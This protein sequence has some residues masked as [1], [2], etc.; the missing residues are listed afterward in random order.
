VPITTSQLF[1]FGLLAEVAVQDTTS[2][3]RKQMEG[4]KLWQ[5]GRINYSYKIKCICGN[6]TVPLLR[7]KAPMAQ[8]QL[9]RWFWHK[10]V[11]LFAS[12]ISLMYVFF[13][14]KSRMLET[15]SWLIPYIDFIVFLRVCLQVKMN[16]TELWRN[17]DDI[18]KDKDDLFKN[19]ACSHDRVSDIYCYK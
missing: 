6:L 5:C 14:Y 4:K 17:V 8:T 2:S 18:L 9:R 11:L 19:G 3:C 15:G 10:A 7:K 12:L 13:V 1:I 16:T